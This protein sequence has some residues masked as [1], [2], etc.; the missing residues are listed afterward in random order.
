MPEVTGSGERHRKSYR[1]EGRVQG[2]GFRAFVLRQARRLGLDGWVR[3]ETDGAVAVEAEGEAA[4]LEAFE[5]RL[6]EGPPAARVA[7]IDARSVPAGVEGTGFEVR[8]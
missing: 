4:T 1:V 5:G 6:R 7:R 3:N 2:V 8:S